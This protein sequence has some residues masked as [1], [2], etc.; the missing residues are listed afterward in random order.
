MSKLKQKNIIGLLTSK[1]KYRT[2]KLLKKFKLIN[3][4]DFIECPN[5]KLKG[6]PTLTRFFNRLT[7][8]IFQK[9]QSIMLR[10]GLWFINA[11]RAGINFI[12]AAYGYGNLKKVKNKKLLIF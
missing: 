12:F 7:N 1:D 9:N 8:M 10:Y 4:F 2:Y 3:Y 6:N 5:N 11:E